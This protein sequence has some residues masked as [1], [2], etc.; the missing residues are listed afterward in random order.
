MELN[1]HF[2]SNLTNDKDN[3]NL[4]DNCTLANSIS[5]YLSLNLK[6]QLHTE[7]KL[8]TSNAFLVAC[9][10]FYL[11]L[12]VACSISYIYSIAGRL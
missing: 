6:E 10:V 12:L 9:S 11:T 5:L 2:G 3:I 7:M 8:F 1:I 4:I